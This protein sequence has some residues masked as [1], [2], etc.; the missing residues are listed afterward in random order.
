MVSTAVDASAVARTVGLKTD[1]RNLAGGNVFYLP[2]R[3]IVVGQGSTAVTYSTDKKRVF[4]GTEA[5]NEY[6]FG[7]PLHLAIDEL[8]PSNGDG[9]GSIPVTAYPL[10]DDASGLAAEGDITPVVSTA[11]LANYKVVINNIPSATFTIEDGDVVADITAKMTTAI[12]AA[13]AIPMTAVD[14]TTTVD[15]T[16]KW[17]G[18]SGNDLYIEIDGPTDKGVTFTITQPTGGA[19]NPAVDGALDQLGNVWETMVVNCLELADST[20]L[21]KYSEVNEGRWGPLVK[22]PFVGVFTGTTDNFSTVTTITDARGS[23]RTNATLVAPSSKD[24]PFVVAARQVARIAPLANNNPP[25]D[26]AGQQATGLTPGPDGDQWDYSVRDA[27]VKAGSSTIE[28]VDNV[29]ELSDTVTMYHPTGDPTPA[30]RY[31]VDIVKVLNINFNTELIFNR[32]DWK[33]APLIPDDQPTVNSTAKKPKMAAAEIAAML[34]NLALEAIISD[35]EFAKGTII[36]QISTSNPKRLDITFTTKISG[37]TNIISID[38]YFGFYFG[39]ATI[40]G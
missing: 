35:A 19:T 20:A 26:Y 12:A 33:G 29:I 22:K 2:Q 3:I 37:N 9:V 16:A 25:N 17:K 30:Y 4:S 13:A 39:T 8:L 27:A 28:V 11:E 15:V 36:A 24:L 6:G 1:F 14:S 7:S 21:N 34:D 38:H 40:V 18:A 10:D 31:V 32:D 5:G 23:D